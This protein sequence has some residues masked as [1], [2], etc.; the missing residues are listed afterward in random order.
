MQL[1]T[2]PFKSHSIKKNSSRKSYNC[3]KKISCGNGTV[4]PL[5][6]FAFQIPP[7]V[8]GDLVFWKILG[9]LVITCKYTDIAIVNISMSENYKK[10]KKSI[11][12]IHV[13]KWI[14]QKDRTILMYSSERPAFPVLPHNFHKNL[15]LQPQT[16]QESWLQWDLI[17]QF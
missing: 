11:I 10:N 9:T 14:C 5:I 6:P 15:R 12:I 17:C 1:I 3:C 13:F 7:E 2:N 16:N 4:W 8:N